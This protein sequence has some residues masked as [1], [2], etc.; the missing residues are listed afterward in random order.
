MQ[1][2]TTLHFAQLTIAKKS[3]RER[4]RKGGDFNDTKIM[5][6]RPTSS[7]INP[8]DNLRPTIKNNENRK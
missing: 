5:E 8:R 7:N 4:E 1:N 2:T 6:W 3:E